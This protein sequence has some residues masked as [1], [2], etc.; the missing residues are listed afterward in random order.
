MSRSPTSSVPSE[1]MRSPIDERMRGGE[2]GN[3]SEYPRDRIRRDE[4]AQAAHRFR[5]LIA[6]GLQ[7]GEGRLLTPEVTDELRARAL[8]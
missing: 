3:I 7:S 5:R 2:R 4:Q 6:D 8:G 1:S